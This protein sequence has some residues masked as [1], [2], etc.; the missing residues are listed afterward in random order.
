MSK[1]EILLTVLILAIS[2]WLT[3]F[4][5]FIIFKKTDKLPKIIEY[6]GKVLPA[7]LMGLL[8]VY[9]VKDYN[10]ADITEIL[11]L[12][13][14]ILAVAALQLIKKNTILSISVGTVLYMILIR[15]I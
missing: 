4:L 7:A 11:P 5:P 15:I 3:R 10:F 2:V 1:T 14:S 6:L 12:G 9:C 8:V 13:V